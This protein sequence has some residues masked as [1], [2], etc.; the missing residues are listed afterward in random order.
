MTREEIY[1]I[2][3]QQYHG[4]VL[5]IDLPKEYVE[6]DTRIHC[7]NEKCFFRDKCVLFDRYIQCAKVFG[8]SVVRS[9]IGDAKGRWKRNEW[10]TDRAND[11]NYMN[12]S[13]G[14]NP[15]QHGAEPC[16][17]FINKQKNG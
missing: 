12:A 16:N 10:E 1:K 2:F 5:A 17:H 6:L 11:V 14:M 15:E 13:F 8:R 7:V 9:C 3:W 4:E